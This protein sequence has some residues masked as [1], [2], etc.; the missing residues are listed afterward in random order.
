MGIEIREQHADRHQADKCEEGD[1][2]DWNV[3]LG[4]WQERLSASAPRARRGECGA[5]PAVDG[6]HQCGQRPDGSDEN[7]ARADEA[8]L[9]APR[10]LGEYGGGRVTATAIQRRVVWDAPQP[11]DDGAEPDRDANPQSYQM[12]DAEERN[13]EEEI[14]A[15]HGAARAEAEIPHEV[16]GE[17]ARGHH[18]RE[19]R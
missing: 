2:T 13:G 5:E 8:D 14:E 7:G 11:G 16:T 12:A 10:L 3:A 17:H 15:G 1:Q 6:L 18:D 9:V 4:A 19:H